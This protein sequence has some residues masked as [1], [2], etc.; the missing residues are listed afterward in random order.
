[1]RMFFA[2]RLYCTFF[3]SSSF[4]E[5]LGFISLVLLITVNGTFGPSSIAFQI[6]KSCDSMKILIMIFQKS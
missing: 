5:D 3:L 6:S 1:M 2:L 4:C